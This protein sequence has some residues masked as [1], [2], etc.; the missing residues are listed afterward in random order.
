MVVTL[1]LLLR[2]RVDDVVVHTPAIRVFSSLSLS[3]LSLSLSLHL[4]LRRWKTDPSVPRHRC[5]CVYTFWAWVWWAPF[6]VWPLVSAAVIFL[7]YWNRYRTTT[8]RERGR[9]EMESC[10][11][12]SSRSTRSN[13]NEA[14]SRGKASV[15]LCGGFGILKFFQ[16]PGPGPVCESISHRLY[17][18][19]L[20]CSLSLSLSLSPSL[21]PRGR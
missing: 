8:T 13:S 6:P 20:S 3:L 14:I 16:C 10:C 18:R 2:T 1:L 4:F 5:C 7:G 17:H 21:S 11:N 19:S 12:N 9:K 15:M